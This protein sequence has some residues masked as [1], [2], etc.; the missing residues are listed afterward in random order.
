MIIGELIIKPTETT[1]LHGDTVFGTIRQTGVGIKESWLIRIP[2]LNFIATE[3][4]R[5]IA[6]DVLVLCYCRGG[7]AA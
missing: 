2:S 7:E 6:E 5:A 4:S 3:K 1:M